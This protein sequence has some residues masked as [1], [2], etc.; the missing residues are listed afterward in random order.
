MTFLSV[1][2]LTE[3]IIISQFLKCWII[4]S[5]LYLVF[6]SN[7]FL[8]DQVYL[9]ICNIFIKVGSLWKTK[10]SFWWSRCV[11]IWYT[12]RHKKWSRDTHFPRR[13]AARFG[14]LVTCICARITWSCF[15]CE[16]GYLL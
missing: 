1:L 9:L 8:S 10:Q 16:R 11:V 4:K 15:A 6:K 7:Q 13:N 2:I 3:Y 5:L 12:L 14:S